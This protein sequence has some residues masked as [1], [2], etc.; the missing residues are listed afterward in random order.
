MART[1]AKVQVTIWQSEDWRGLPMVSQWLYI[2]LLTQSRLS[3]AGCVDYS[4]QRWVTLTPDASL[5]SVEHALEV[6]ER[7]QYV[8][9]D[10]STAE[11][12]IRTFTTHDLANGTLNVNLVKGFWTAWDGILSANLRHYVVANLPA[13]VWDWDKVERPAEAEK[14]RQEPWPEPWFST[15]ESWDVSPDENPTSDRLEPWSQPSVALT[16]SVSTTAAEPDQTVDEKV[17]AAARLLAAAE[18]ERRGRTT[19]GNHEGY[20]RSRLKQLTEQNIDRWQAMLD[21]DPTTTPEQLIDEPKKPANVPAWVAFDDVT[22]AASERRYE[23]AEKVRSG[24][25]C[26]RCRGTGR[27]LP[28]DSTVMA[29][30]SCASTPSR[31]EN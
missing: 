17:T 29:A 26:G 16:A 19:I 30:C 21:A 15:P 4:P 23:L 9:V 18:I 14:M 24:E 27:Y 10:R 31:E 13:R 8:A 5:S 3:L 20:I 7:A 6:L 2:V 25:V 12:V 1:L 11:V 22:V 28:D